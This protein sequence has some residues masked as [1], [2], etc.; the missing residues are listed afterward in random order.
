MLRYVVLNPLRAGM[1]ERPEDYR[2]SSYRA[3][4]G[5]E[6]APEWLDVRAALDPFAPDVA[7]AVG[8]YREFVAEKVGSDERLWD[9]LIN[10]IYLGSEAW[11]K[12]MRKLVESKP[13][14]T[15]HPA[16]HRAVGRPKMAHV[17]EAVGNVAGETAWAIRHTRGGTLRRLAAWIGWNEGWQTLR[18]IA[19]SLRLRSEGHIS[20]L[21]RRCERE[22][23]TDPTLLAQLDG[24]LVLLR[25]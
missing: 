25:A 14:S 5:L 21:I 2:W 18:A 23:G 22:F 19:A 12:R 10:G 17:I 3:T 15:D 1:V 7:V 11:T 4:A 9:H 24:A 13:R 8:Y 6:S 20:N 16:A